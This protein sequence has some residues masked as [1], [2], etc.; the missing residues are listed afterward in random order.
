MCQVDL[1][2]DE[3]DV[4]RCVRRR[5]V[6]KV[7][8]LGLESVERLLVSDVVASDAPMGL[9]E[10]CL[11]DGAEAFLPGCVPHLHLSDSVLDLQRFDFEIDAD[12][13]LHGALELLRDESNKDRSLSRIAVT[14]QNDFEKG[15]ICWLLAGAGKRR[16]VVT[17]AG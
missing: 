3:D 16:S 14:D 11:T 5:I 12:G 8:D 1:V 2:S 15:D 4:P 6:D 9:P 10:V 7:A 17:G 13:V